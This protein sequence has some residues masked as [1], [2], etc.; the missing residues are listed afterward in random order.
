MNPRLIELALKKQQLV[1]RSAVLRQDWRRHASILEPWCTGVD[2]VRDAG[3]WL[4]QH[5]Q[6]LAGVA[7]TLLVARP[8]AVFRWSRRAFAAFG[9]WRQVR[10]WLAG[11]LRR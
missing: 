10:G 4:R 2:R 8:R 5:P 9:Y 11:P 7:T 6:W 1:S 3:R